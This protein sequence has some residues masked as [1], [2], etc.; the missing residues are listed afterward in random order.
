MKTSIKI[1]DGQWMKATHNARPDRGGDVTTL[2]TRARSRRALLARHGTLA[3]A[4]V[5]ALV[6]TSAL[7][8]RGRGSIRAAERPA[9]PAPVQQHA[10]PA[11]EQPAR[12]EPAREQPAHAPPAV[13]HENRGAPAHV[14]EQRRPEEPRRTEGPAHVEEAHR[15]PEPPHVQAPARRDWDEHDENAQHF[16]GFGRGEP[17]RAHRG[18]RVRVLPSHH[19]DV[20]FNRHHYFLDD[21]GIYYD[22]QPDGEY[23]VVQP[24]V[25]IVVGALP[26]GATP[27]AVG[28]TT[29]YYLDGDFYVAQGGGFA[30]VNPPPGIVV[31]ALPSGASQVVVNGAVVYQFN[32]FNY[33]P[34]LQDGVTVYTVTPA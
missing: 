9:A 34:A 18:D 19:F 10:A 27:I 33:T 11:H 17:V 3:F 25:G 7:A 24:P 30:I 13:S 5:L 6:S 16:G 2:A 28:P 31:P 26:E 8:D 1:L 4:G 15:A 14:E 20:E 23:L 22:V 29:Y 12:G 32:G 21:A